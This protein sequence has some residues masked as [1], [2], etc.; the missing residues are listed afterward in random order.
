MPN[1]GLNAVNKWNCP[2]KQSN[3][4]NQ[5]LLS[6]NQ[7]RRQGIYKR[8]YRYLSNRANNRKERR[9]FWPSIQNNKNSPPRKIRP[10]YRIK[11]TPYLH[12]NHRLVHLPSKSSRV[13]LSLK[14][15]L[16]GRSWLPYHK[17]TSSNLQRIFQRAKL[18]YNKHV[19]PLRPLLHNI[20]N[21]VLHLG[22]YS[23]KKRISNNNNN[24]L[25][26]RAD[27]NH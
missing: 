9:I 3:I 17:Q 8:H 23:P 18:N 4:R 2:H 15:L 25:Y 21:K 27:R 6:S 16:K 12:S 22:R 5:Q 10:Q 13:I 7:K 26:S 20:L 14:R 24:R 19:Q 1:I 11:Y